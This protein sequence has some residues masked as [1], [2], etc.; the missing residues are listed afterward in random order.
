[1]TGW[2]PQTAAEGKYYITLLTSSLPSAKLDVMEATGIKP[3]GVR[4]TRG[5][6]VS[7]YH[8]TQIKEKTVSVSVIFKEIKFSVWSSRFNHFYCNKFY[9]C[10]ELPKV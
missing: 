10:S 1:M 2:T 4:F 7:Y 3:V 8:N 5:P 6:P 9:Y